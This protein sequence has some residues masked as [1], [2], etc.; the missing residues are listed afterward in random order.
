MGRTV[1]TPTSSNTTTATTT[2]VY[3]ST[4]ATYT[5]AVESSPVLGVLRNA[6]RGVSV[7][8]ST[9]GAGGADKIQALISPICNSTPIV[10]GLEHNNSNSSCH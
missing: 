1:V 6:H 8:R 2:T 4:P 10:V 5:T 9:S 3:T 7:H